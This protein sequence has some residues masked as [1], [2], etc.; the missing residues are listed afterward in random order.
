[1]SAM[2]Y[3]AVIMGVLNIILIIR[4]SLWNFPVGIIMVV[5]YCIIF[6]QAKLYSDAGL[7]VFF[8]IIQAYGWYA[9]RKNKIAQGAVIVERLS[10]KELGLW[11]T[12]SLLA[13]VVWGILMHRFTDASYPYWDAMIA[14]FSIAAQIMMSRRYLE[15]WWLW[16]AV[17]CLSIPLYLL[18]GLYPTAGLYALF[19]ILAV[20]GLVDWQRQSRI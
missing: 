13:T 9:W 15:N 7:Q 10:P 17:N 16:I 19:L 6:T 11:I 8:V 5:L 3:A 18:K 1:M 12:G 14:M 20:I 4:R 2:E